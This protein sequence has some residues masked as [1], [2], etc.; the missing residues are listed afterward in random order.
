MPPPQTEAAVKCWGLQGLFLPSDT[1][2]H[3]GTCFAELYLLGPVIIAQEI[4]PLA[5]HQ[6][7]QNPPLSLLSAGW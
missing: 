3:A 4:I 2:M 7:E 6:K 1:F 5:I